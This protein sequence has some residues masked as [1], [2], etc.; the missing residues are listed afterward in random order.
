MLDLSSS[1]VS[2]LG[3]EMGLMGIEDTMNDYWDGQ[4]QIVGAFLL[5]K[6]IFLLKSMCLRQDQWIFQLLI[7][8]LKF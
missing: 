1:I 7:R 3:L 8:F 6:I 5:T 2:Q 4:Q